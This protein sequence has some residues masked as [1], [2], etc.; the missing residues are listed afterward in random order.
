MGGC[1]AESREGAVWGEGDRDLGGHGVRG[2]S[3][4]RC[5]AAHRSETAREGSGCPTNRTIPIPGWICF[6]FLLFPF[7]TDCL[8]FATDWCPFFT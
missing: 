3:C 4:A 2:R 1:G 8:F 6:F 7:F 5:F